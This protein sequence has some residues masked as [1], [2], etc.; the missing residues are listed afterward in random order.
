MW[1]RSSKMTLYFLIFYFLYGRKTLEST[2]LSFPSSFSLD[3]ITYFSHIVFVVVWCLVGGIILFLD[4][5]MFIKLIHWPWQASEAELFHL[6]IWKL[7]G[8]GVF[9][10]AKFESV[11]DNKIY[12]ANRYLI[13]GHSL[14][15]LCSVIFPVLLTLMLICRSIKTPRYLSTEFCFTSSCRSV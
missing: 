5:S 4:G 9:L 11:A 13:S 7:S 6:N 10:L 1:S 3:K 2:I 15:H 12:K 8:T 14:E